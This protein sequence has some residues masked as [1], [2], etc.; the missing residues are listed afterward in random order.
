MKSDR[1]HRLNGDGRKQIDWH[2]SSAIRLWKLFLIIAKA[3]HFDAP[4]G[5]P[6]RFDL[7]DAPCRVQD[8]DDAHISTEQFHRTRENLIKGLA[9]VVRVPQPRAYLV[10]A[11]QGRTLLRQLRFTLAELL[12]RL[13][14]LREQ[15]NQN[16]REKCDRHRRSL[17]A[18]H[19]LS[20]RHFSI[21]KAAYAK[22][23]GQD[24]RGRGDKC[25]SPA[26]SRRASGRQP[27][28]QGQHE[29]TS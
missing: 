23:Y 29:G 14:A 17:G 19:T 5:S 21:A 22:G 3:Q 8:P 9:Q 26:E 10:Q 2:L 7:Q 15:G 11:S 13:F 24:D 28:Q 16:E 6:R 4:S 12:L 18:S 25:T 27:Q 20:E 1:D